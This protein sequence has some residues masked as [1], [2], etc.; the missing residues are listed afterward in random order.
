MRHVPF[1]LEMFRIQHEEGRL[2]VFEQPRALA[3]LAATT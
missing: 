1:C 2:F 3:L